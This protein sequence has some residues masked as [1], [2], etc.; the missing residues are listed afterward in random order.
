MGRAPALIAI[1]AFAA[2]GEDVSNGDA[3]V[4]DAHPGAIDA[5]LVNFSFTGTFLDWDSTTTAPC[6]IVGAKWYATYDDSRV[7]ITDADGA[8]S[9]RLASYTP[10]LDVVPPANASGCANGSYP[11]HGIAIAPPAV[12][13]AGGAFQARSMTTARLSTFFASIGTPFDP[14]RGH[15]LV[16]V[17]GVPRSL[18]I[19]GN[20]GLP[21][22]FDG[23]VWTAGDAGRD[24]FFPNIEIT[25]TTPMTTVAV[26]GGNALGLGAVPIAAGAF[27]Y[28][29][30]VL[31]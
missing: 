31:N 21:Q 25:G 14:A 15:L 16:H 26:T 12:V 8:F 18:S 10:L 17:N 9:I 5:D 29:A 7:A 2:C 11:Q 13:A 22:T 23:A 28:M 4:D 24:V 30:V 3:G 27:T 19:T 1:L 6:P 20:H